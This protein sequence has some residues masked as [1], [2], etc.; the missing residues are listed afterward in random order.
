MPVATTFMAKDLVPDEH[1]LFVGHPG[2]RGNRGA[3]FAVQSADVILTMGCSL[4]LQT[5]GDEGELFAPNA[6][7]IQIDLDR[8]LLQRDSTGAQW[9]F[10]WDLHRP[11]VRAGARPSP[12]AASAGGQSVAPG[13]RATLPATNLTSLVGLAIP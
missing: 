8:A 6:L 10:A 4:H 13:S 7:K 2:P 9:K 12:T 3:N 5:V 11:P 1:P